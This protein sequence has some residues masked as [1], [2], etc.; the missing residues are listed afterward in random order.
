[1]KER[2]PQHW[3]SPRYPLPPRHALSRNR[4]LKG[5]GLFDASA[6]SAAVES[7][8]NLSASSDACSLHRRAEA[9]DAHEGDGGRGDGV[10]ARSA[11]RVASA[12]RE[13]S[14]TAPVRK[15]VAG[16]KVPAAVR[17]KSSRAENEDNV[18]MS[19]GL[20]SS[21]TPGEHS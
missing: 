11:V 6:V 7:A 14:K 10:Q 3:S 4:L 20:S 18:Q 1:M 13:V 15:D 8:G 21:V 19:T 2:C 12:P 9:G 16:A 5:I 17:G